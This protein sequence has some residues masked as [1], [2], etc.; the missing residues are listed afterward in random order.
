MLGLDAAG[1]AE[2]VERYVI[3]GLDNEEGTEPSRLWQSQQVGEE[4]GG[5]L[6]VTGVDD[7][8]V[9]LNWHAPWLLSVG[10]AMAGTAPGTR[11]AGAVHLHLHAYI[12]MFSLVGA[13]RYMRRTKPHR[14]VGPKPVT[15]RRSESGVLRLQY[16]W[17]EDPTIHDTHSSAAERLV[18]GVG[19]VLGRPGF[20]TSAA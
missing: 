2:D 13:L 15:S 20:R 18:D 8:V 19:T 14:T 3:G 9:E 1:I 5:P 11:S 6:L 12:D 4:S 16:R 17:A 10:G 7:G